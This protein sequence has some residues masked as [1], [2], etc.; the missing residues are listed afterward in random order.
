MKELKFVVL[1]LCIFLYPGKSHAV[2]SCWGSALWFR[3]TLAKETNLE[4]SEVKPP[5]I[6]IALASQR[7]SKQTPGVVKL[8]VENTTQAELRLSEPS[9]FFL[10]KLEPDQLKRIT[11][12]YTASVRLWECLPTTSKPNENWVLLPGESFEC[13]IDLT[14]L[15]WRLSKS[16]VYDISPVYP[17]GNLFHEVP[18]GNYKL[19]FGLHSPQEL[20][21]GLPRTGL[22]RSNELSV[23]LDR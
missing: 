14:K 4:D 10:Q 1:V 6:S 12:G 5:S 15:N 9:S 16:A 23:A 13:K 2:T 20:I 7:L 18:S 3:P 17:A 11:E 21:R 22:F 19:F 8:R